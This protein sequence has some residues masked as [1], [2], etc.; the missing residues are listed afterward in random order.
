MKHELTVG[1][2]S[3]SLAL[4]TPFC[5]ADDSVETN[6]T[7]KVDL[8]F[9]AQDMDPEYSPKLGT[10]SYSI[11]WVMKT[12]AGVE[13]CIARSGDQYIMT[14]SARTG[15][16]VDLFYKVRY[17]GEAALDMTT[18]RPS[19]VELNEQV[20]S[21]H[22]HTMMGFDD[23]VL[24]CKRTRWK[25]KKAPFSIVE[26]DV[27]TNNGVIKDYFSAILMARA[28]PWK[29]G[30]T[31]TAVVFDGRGLNDVTLDCLGQELVK[32]E[33]KKVEAWHLKVKIVQV[34]KVDEDDELIADNIHLY[35]TSDEAREIVCIE[36]DTVYGD[37]K[38][39][40]NNFKPS[41]QGQT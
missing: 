22:K 36:A 23:G 21:T 34:G 5:M 13:I 26:R 9:N 29:K 6:L 32:I 2:L 28:L 27:D 11:Y 40:L 12:G 41:P 20:R 37:I 31:R 8:G 25:K 30:D 35:L 17:W 14:T 18:L 24:H 1:L 7:V 15:R 4:L 10:Y 19:E 16:F 3:L 39:K 38:I 33:K